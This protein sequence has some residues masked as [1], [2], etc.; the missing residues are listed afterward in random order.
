[1]IDN[2]LKNEFVERFILD[3]KTSEKYF[4]KKFDNID[5]YPFDISKEIVLFTFY[6]A[7]FKYK[8]II[9]DEEY[10]NDYLNDLDRLFKKIINYQD[11]NDCINKLIC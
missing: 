11:I 4:L 6:E 1:M 3:I 10:L 7:L 8:I 9:D 5:R 2:L